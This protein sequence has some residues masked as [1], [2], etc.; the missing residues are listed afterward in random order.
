MAWSTAMD[1]NY[2]LRGGDYHLRLQLE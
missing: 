1:E 2:A